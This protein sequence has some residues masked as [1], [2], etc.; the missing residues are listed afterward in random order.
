MFAEKFAAKIGH[1]VIHEALIDH[2]AGR[3]TEIGSGRT[4][5][6][7]Y[8]AALKAKRVKFTKTGSPHFTWGS[9]DPEARILAVKSGL[10]IIDGA[11]RFVV[12]TDRCQNMI[13][14]AE[15]Y[16]NAKDPKTGLPLDKPLKLNDHLMDDWGYLAMHKLT[17]KSA[18]PMKDSGGEAFQAMK[19]K[20]ARVKTKG[21]WGGG[22]IK[23]G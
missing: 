9:D 11:S 4:V 12:F 15:E 5:E 16:C 3:C 2:H 20:K 21:G 14:E 8:R 10:T 1:D 6:E 19:A 22:S 13:K 18:K 7:Q 23:V 17:Y